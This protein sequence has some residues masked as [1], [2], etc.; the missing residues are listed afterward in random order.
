MT[1]ENVTEAESIE[2]GEPPAKAWTTGRSTSWWG[3][4]GPRA[5]S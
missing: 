5:C 4:P 1:S 2:S 3:G